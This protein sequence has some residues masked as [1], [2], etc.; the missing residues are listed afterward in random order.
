[1]SWSYIASGTR[2]KNNQIIYSRQ[3]LTASQKEQA[4]LF[5]QWLRFNNLSQTLTGWDNNWLPEGL[6]HCDPEVLATMIN[7]FDRTFK[8][9]KPNKLLPNIKCPVLLIR[10]NPVHGSLISDNDF[11]NA[12]KLLPDLSH[13]MIDNAGHSPIRQDAAAVLVAIADFIKAQGIR[14][15]YLE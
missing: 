9:Y 12:L 4:N 7:N 15:K 6:R 10:G 8:E 14:F 3:K 11:K 5:I 13:V 2:I 1:M